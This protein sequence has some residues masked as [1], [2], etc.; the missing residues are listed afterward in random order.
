LHNS[1]G[2]MEFVRH[3][4]NLLCIELDQ[5]QDQDQDTR[6]AVRELNCRIESKPMKSMY[7]KEATSNNGRE[8]AHTGNGDR[9]SGEGGYDHAQLRAHGYE[10]EPD[11]FV[12]AS[13]GE[14][15]PI[16]KVPATLFYLFAM[17][18][19]DPRCRIIFSLCTDPWTRTRN[20]SRK[21]FG[22]IRTSS[23]CSD[24]LIPSHGSPI[25][26]SRWSIRSTGGPSYPNWPPSRVTS[27]SDVTYLKAR[28]PN[29]AWA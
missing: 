26:L 3:L 8:C 12:D 5:D 17:L 4:Y 24:F 25:I 19:L 13:G 9:T 20:S 11:V 21:R 1:V 7:T 16:Y 6:S 18:T 22:R 29:S 27:T 23:R 15:G 2:R 28:F 10:V 14:W